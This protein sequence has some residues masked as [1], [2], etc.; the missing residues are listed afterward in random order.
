M[1]MHM[2]WCSMPP[3]TVGSATM[4][5]CW[6]PCLRDSPQSLFRSSCPTL[7]RSSPCRPPLKAGGASP[8]PWRV[9]APTTPPLCK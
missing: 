3:S 2:H 4:R 9:P 8:C 7:S 6:H 1:G 5:W